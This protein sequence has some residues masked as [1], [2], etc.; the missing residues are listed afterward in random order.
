MWGGGGVGRDAHVRQADR[1]GHLFQPRLPPSPTHT[2][3]PTPTNSARA[4]NHT[5][6]IARSPIGPLPAAQ[7]LSLRIALT[8][9][10]LYFCPP[11][12][13]RPAHLTPPS[14]LPQPALI[15]TFV[16][17]ARQTSW[18]AKHPILIYRPAAIAEAAITYTRT[19]VR[20][21]AR[22]HIHTFK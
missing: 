17:P 10:D 13:Y 20:T 12:P 22:R 19:D 14:P 15:R 8:H 1:A 4:R 3:P 6:A 18:P 11:P 2:Q 16:G 21:R 7:P 5:H 9:S